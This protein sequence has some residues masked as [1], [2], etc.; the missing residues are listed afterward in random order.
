MISSK[1]SLL[2]SLACAVATAVAYGCSGSEGAIEA[3]DAAPAPDASRDGGGADASSI[4]DATLGD[5]ASDA[6]TTADAPS[7]D[8]ADATPNDA[9]AD[10]SD[11]GDASSDASE[12]VNAD[13]SDGA[14]DGASEDAS[15]AGTSDA[16]TTDGCT[17]SPLACDGVAHACDGVVDEGCPSSLTLTPPTTASPLWGEPGGSPYTQSCPPGEVLIGL[18][19]ARGT[20]PDWLRSVSAICGITSMTKVSPTSYAVSITPDAILG[21]SG[22]VGQVAWSTQCG[23]NQAVFFITPKSGAYMDSVTLECAPIAISGSPGSFTAKRG[24]PVTILPTTGGS[25]GGPETPP[26]FG[27]PI[28][29]VMNVVTGDSSDS[30]DMMGVICSTMTVTLN[31]S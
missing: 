30:L 10:A 16:S 5:D 3:I 24:T 6:S 28:N 18:K 7:D 29:Q 19:G 8:A 22:G 17:P 14:S 20:S 1:R 11:G 25:G 12:D 31:G 9:S 13:T 26:R 15:D 21:P 27:C 4:I 23:A 2:A